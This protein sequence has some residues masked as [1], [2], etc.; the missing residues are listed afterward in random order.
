MANTPKTALQEAIYSCRK[1]FVFIVIFSFAINV[2][3]MALPIYSMQVLD[4][5]ISSGSLETLIMLSVVIMAV[6]VATGLIQAARSMAFV[7]IGQWLDDKLATGLLATSISVSSQSNSPMG[8][9]GLRDLNTVR[10]FLTG[11]PMVTLVDAPWAVIYIIAIFI[12]HPA[13]GI[14]AI[15]G[16]L[17][18][19]G[20]AY[21]NNLASKE[22]LAE[23]NDVGIKSMATIDMASRNAEVVE[24]MGM[25]PAVTKLWQKTN[26]KAI[27][28][29]TIASDRGAII[30]SISKILRY[31]LQVFITGAGAYYTLENSL[32]AGGIIASSILLGRAMA[33][34]DTAIE[35]WKQVI[36]ARKSYE[37][38]NKLVQNKYTRD[39]NM[40]LPAPQ[41]TLSVEN[42]IFG[43][44][45]SK[46]PTIKG[47]SFAIQP[48]D[49]LGV[50]GPSAAG[51]STLAKLIMGVWK[52]TAGAVRLDGSDVFTWNRSEFG[53]HVGYLPQDVELFPG[54]I[55]D[56][57]G[58]LQEDASPEMIVE[59]AR[60]AGVHEMIV[61]LPDGYDTQIGVGG[62]ILS[63]G[64]R[65]RVGLARAFYGNPRLMVLDEP[66]ANLDDVGERALMEALHH[67]KSLSITTIIISHRPAILQAVDKLLYVNDGMV[68]A[69]GSRQDVLTKISRPITPTP[70]VV[71]IPNA[72]GNTGTTGQ[73][74]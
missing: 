51:K 16:G 10:Q 55:K 17:L 57:I 22:P 21:I 2:L 20:L 69:F 49:I 34:F 52:P 18:I 71:N 41:G 47:I 66:N 43:P 48:G 61:R 59:A 4:R 39:D 50:I 30:S 63:A 74:G 27:G 24:A 40:S 5:V 60:L 38:L 29:Q 3:V 28:L 25:L 32:S 9:Q 31:S 1:A 35:T 56:N 46:K 23:A 37:R 14:I 70:N 68:A 62:S 11:S 45:G 54:T 42:V 13:N 36:G 8:S 33:P 64:Q 44:M 67:A 58:R 53:Q 12:I 65:Q 19:L 7:R 26:Q 6:F 15:V 73:Q 72:G